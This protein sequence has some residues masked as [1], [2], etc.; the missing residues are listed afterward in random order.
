M[1]EFLSLFKVPTFLRA[2]G[3]A[4]QFRK[5]ETT[6]GSYFVDWQ[7][8]TVNALLATQGLSADDLT[9]TRPGELHQLTRDLLLLGLRDEM[10]SGR[11]S[12]IA[13]FAR[14]LMRRRHQS[15]QVPSAA[16]SPV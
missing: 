13:R 8:E 5:L 9:E 16:S 2:T 12:P 1:F 4:A 6:R 10:E 14:A 3:P 11:R 7:P 15:E